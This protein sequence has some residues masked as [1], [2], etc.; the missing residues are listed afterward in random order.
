MR[1]WLLRAVAGGLTVASLAACGGAPPPP[2][3]TVV[4]LTLAAGADVN[5]SPSGQASPI[6]LRVYQLGS[7]AGFTNA[8][9]F[10]LYND[11]AAALKTDLIKR[12]DFLL[13]PG[14]TRLDTIMPNDQVK[15]IGILAAYRDFQHTTWRATVD[16]VPHQTSAVTA[17]AGHDGLTVKPGS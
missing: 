13:A 11:D 6:A 1:G 12:E 3:P 8:E 16:V 17:T 2:P 4:K 10:P 14:Q 5:P 9:F 15:A 7:A